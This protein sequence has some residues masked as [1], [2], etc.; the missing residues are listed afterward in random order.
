ML[1]PTLLDS[2]QLTDDTYTEKS[3][4]DTVLLAGVEQRRMIISLAPERTPNAALDGPVS[5]HHC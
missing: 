3:K 5:R 2:L 4:T 1:Q